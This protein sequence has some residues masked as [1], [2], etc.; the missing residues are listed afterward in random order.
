MINTENIIIRQS[1]YLRLN[2][3]P[4]GCA[5]DLLN[6]YWIW[7]LLPLFATFGATLGHFMDTF[8]PPSYFCSLLS[9]FDHCLLFAV[10]CYR[11][12]SCWNY[13]QL[14]R[15]LTDRPP[16][17]F[18]C[19]DRL[20]L[21]F[22]VQDCTNT[23]IWPCLQARFYIFSSSLLLGFQFLHDFVSCPSAFDNATFNLLNIKCFD[24]WETNMTNI[25]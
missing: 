7:W 9:T 16:Q 15:W 20:S 8:G 5:S 11:W 3:A 6:L 14:A 24:I 2:Q 22:S 18:R 4:K 12:P 21:R 10:D 19:L 17:T 25:E 1:L 13:L 23:N